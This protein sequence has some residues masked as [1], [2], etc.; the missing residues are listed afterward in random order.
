[1]SLY[2]EYYFTI[3]FKFCAE[4]GNIAKLHQLLRL[5]VLQGLAVLSLTLSQ[6]Y[7]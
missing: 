6:A 1:M 5:P 3:Y 4:F 2:I 7:K